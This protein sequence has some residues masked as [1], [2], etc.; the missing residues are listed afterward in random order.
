VKAKENLIAKSSPDDGITISDPTNGRADIYL[1]PADTID[2]EPTTYKF[3][4]WLETVAQ[5]RYVVIEPS[6]FVV[7]DPVSE[8]PEIP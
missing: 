8:L 6:N 1:E 7:A 5:D 3:D 4:V 2:L